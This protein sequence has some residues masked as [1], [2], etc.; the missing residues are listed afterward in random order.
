MRK[1]NGWCFKKLLLLA[2]AGA[3]VS[4]LAITAYATDKEGMALTRQ[5]TKSP[6]QVLEGAPIEAGPI[7]NPAGSQMFVAG[8]TIVPICDGYID[9]G[10]WSDAY[11]Y[12]ISDTTGQSDGIPDPLGTVTLWL[13]QDGLGV[14][15]AIR[16]NAD[17]TLDDHD[18]CCV[19]FDDN[20][21]GCWPASATNEGNSWVVYEP[22]GPGFVQWRWWQ[23]Y[24]CGFPPDYTCAH[25][26]VD[27]VGNWSPTCF[28]IGIGPTGNVD[29]EIMIPY[30]TAD[31]HLDLTMPP[32]SLGFY[33]YCFDYPTGNYH[34]EWPSQYY[35]ETFREPCYF[36][37]LVC[38]GQWP[39]HKMHFPQLPDLIGWDVFA[40]EPFTLGD[41]WQCSRTGPVTDIHFW[42][43]WKDQDGNP[44]TDEVGQLNYFDFGI[45]S[46]LPAG[47]PQN[48]YPYSIPGDLLWSRQEWLQGTSFEPPTMEAWYEP[49]WDSSYCNDHIP[50]WQYDFVDIPDPFMQIQDS[51]YWLT[52]SA[53]LDDPNNF[54]WGWKSSRDHFMDD[55]VWTDNPGMDWYEMYEPPRC[56]WFDVY[57]SDP[58]TPPEDMGSTNYYGAGWY[59]YE[60]D[61]WWNMWF[62]NNPFTF[63]QVKEIFMDF[64]IEEAGPGAYAEFAINWSTPEWD[65]LEM[66]RPPLPEDEWV[67]PGFIG[68]EIFEVYPGPNYIDYVIPYNPEWVSID[69]RATDVIVNGWI[70]HECVQTSMDLAFVITGPDVTP[71]IDVEKKVWDA[72]IPGWVD[73]TDIDSCTNA[74]FQ[75]TIRNTGTCDLTDVHIHDFMDASLEFISAQP[76][77]DDIVPAADGVNLYWNPIDPISAG[78]SMVIS[79][80]AH[81]IGPVCHLDSNWVHAEGFCEPTGD[82][83]WDEDVAYVHA[84]EPEWPDHKMHFPQLPNPEGWDVLATY[85]V[86]AADD[87]RCSESGPITGIHFWGSWWMNDIGVINGFRLSIHSNI[88]GPPYSQPGDT[89]WTAYITDFVETPMEPDTQGWYDPLQNFWEPLDHVDYFRYDITNIPEPFVQDSGTIYWLDIMAFV[90]GP[91]YPDAPLWGWKTSLVHWEDDAVWALDDPPYYWLPLED[92]ITGMTLDLA[93]VITTEE[94]QVLCG[95]VNHSGA[96]DAGDVVYLISYLFRGG[97]APSPLLQG[98][99]NCSG[100][101]DAGDVV[102]LI[103]YLFRGGPDPCDPDDDGIPDC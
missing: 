26:D 40:T 88:P 3:L 7:H 15:F 37:R 45:W 83:V 57:F 1:K 59:F 44:L 77:P 17:Q 72:T 96:V 47:H 85:P 8:L 43:S 50:Y 20:Y 89:L 34:G 75:A 9:A 76:P 4:S 103:S 25:D 33:V 53:F 49:F 22:P 51:I 55:A 90:A 46:N 39:E 64:W 36:G 69:F 84:T 100:A 94:Q 74:Q 66:D 67:N 73:S 12:D 56:N 31:E 86:V 63:D 70:W 81:V 27:I 79:L 28:G 101:V 35:A 6:A 41:D 38:A 16:N 18:Q 61:F 71:G 24:D 29:F 42:G 30:G 60:Y 58:L 99:V 32:D 87:F 65:T 13:K 2:I 21:D 102:Y 92:P 82:W 68:R 93:F 5:G 91:G 97:P 80:T 78:D 10:E 19:T 11:V 95:D 54:Q 23:D 48:P 14:Y 98:D 52:I 62:Y